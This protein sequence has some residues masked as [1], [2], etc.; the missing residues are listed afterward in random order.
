M[1]RSPEQARAHILE[2]AAR[3]FAVRLPDQ[4]GL[5]DVAREAQVSHALVTHYFGTYAA[6][7]EAVLERRFLL[8]RDEVVQAVARIAS[9]GG[10][11]RAI[12]A[13]Q[14]GAVR[15]MAADPLAVRLA[16]YA[17]LS[18]RAGA[19]DFFPARIQGL[20]LLADVIEARSGAP[21][22]D[23]EV[24][25]VTSLATTIV[26]TVGKHTLVGALGRRWTREEDAA[27]ER[28]ITRM[29]DRMM[30]G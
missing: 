23:V 2:A 11:T 30:G 9:E 26:W 15:R 28:G 14:R 21:R 12:L 8:L 3:V 22:E 6:L 18:G 19:D 5:K 29:L 13:E 10:D 17:L 25:I 1:R 24:A 16:V 4:V 7:V 27:F 20:K